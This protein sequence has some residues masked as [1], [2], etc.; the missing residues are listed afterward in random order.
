MK[1]LTVGIPCYNEQLTVA[2]VVAEYRAT[3]PQARILVIDN[4]STDAT[5]A[6]A[7]KAGADVISETRKGKG[8]A[9]QRLFSEC[10]SDL[11]LMV[12]GDH[13][14]PAAES[15]KLVAA[16]ERDG[17]DTVVG[18]RT[19]DDPNAFKAAHSWANDMLA[20]IIGRLFGG[21][22]GDLFS[23]MRLFTRAFYRNVPMLSSG[24]E[25]ETEIAL[26]TL[27]KGFTQT[28]V[29]ITFRARPEG[30]HSK[31][32]T[33]RD[34][35]RVLR[36]ILFV[37]KDFKPLLFFGLCAMVFFAC[38]LLAGIFPVL[39]YV[40]FHYI[41]KV[42]LAILATGLAMLGALCFTCGL[43]L[44]TIVRLRREEFFLRMRNWPRT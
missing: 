21:A 26:H 32:N 8:F 22:C 19:S 24:F 36:T 6:V 28:N 23:G 40:H 33:F 44:D 18:T 43:I 5:A 31:L 15:A 16:Q 11:L 34:G 42:P 29:D 37:F 41:Y 25:V 2:D 39:D 30:S 20:R 14:Y 38:S 17:A 3:F 13:T 1:T 27:D 35:T 4:A 9:V 7:R 10:D 12:D